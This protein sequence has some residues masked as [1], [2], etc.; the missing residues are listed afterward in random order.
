MLASSSSFLFSFFSSLLFS[1]LVFSS[2]AG[3]RW[4]E[5]ASDDSAPLVLVGDGGDQP[6][7]PRHAAW[8]RALAS[9]AGL[10][11]VFLVPK[12]YSWEV[13]IQVVVALSCI[14]GGSIVFACTRPTEGV[15]VREELVHR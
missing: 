15:E 6:R 4:G 9:R 8:P 2:D 5:A 10:T 1:S 14:I 3:G 11:I 13:A 7:H 12:E